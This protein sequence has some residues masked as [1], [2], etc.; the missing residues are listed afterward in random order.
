MAELANRCSVTGVLTL[1]RQARSETE[2]LEDFG[3]R[4]IDVGVDVG[5]TGADIAFGDRTNDTVGTGRYPGDGRT[6]TFLLIVSIT[7][8]CNSLINV[9]I[10]I[11][12]IYTSMVTTM[13]QYLM[14]LLY[15]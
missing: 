14:K 2:C 12:F 15:N 5:V 10:P 1:L 4:K 13:Q 3:V 11:E 6:D 7:L 9:G 8:C